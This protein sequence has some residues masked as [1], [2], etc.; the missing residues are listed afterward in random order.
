MRKNLKRF[1]AALFVIAI[2][3][4]NINGFE[5]IQEVKAA[6]TSLVTVKNYDFESAKKTAVVNGKQMTGAS[7]VM[8]R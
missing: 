6:D 3:L 4:T 5:A 2:C 8:Q 7:K 1:L